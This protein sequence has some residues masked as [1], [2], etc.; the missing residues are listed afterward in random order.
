[1]KLEERALRM[2]LDT[3]LSAYDREVDPEIIREGFANS[4][5]RVLDEHKVLVWEPFEDYPLAAISNFI[6]N[7]VDANLHNLR[8][9]RA[10][11]D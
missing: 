5:E 2:A 11:E 7:E 3:F 1:M 10:R 4:D 6:E 8:L 9:I